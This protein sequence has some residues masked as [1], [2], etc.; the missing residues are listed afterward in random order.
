MFF[1]SPFPI[2]GIA[3]VKRRKKIV[4]NPFVSLVALFVVCF[5]SS[6][7][8]SS[9]PFRRPLFF[10]GKKKFI[11]AFVILSHKVVIK[12][13]KLSESDSDDENFSP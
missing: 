3:L 7:H 13:F 5:Y 9:P 6:A 12:K 1:L 2:N 8:G 11:L 10:S 4:L